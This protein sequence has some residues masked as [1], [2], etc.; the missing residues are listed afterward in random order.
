MTQPGFLFFLL[1]F[2][3][4]HE[5]EWDEKEGKWRLRPS[6]SSSCL[7]RRVRKQNKIKSWLCQW[8]QTTQNGRFVMYGPTYTTD[9]FINK[10]SLKLCREIRL[11]FFCNPR[12]LDLLVEL[13]GKKYQQSVWSSVLQSSRNSMNNS[14]VNFC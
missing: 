7:F 6:F 4:K 11:K 1:T 10:F 13:S 14:S 3:N 9:F 8:T 5:K 2:F 12:S